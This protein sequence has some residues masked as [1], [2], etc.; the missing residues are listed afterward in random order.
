VEIY[1]ALI[2]SEVLAR[3]CLHRTHLWRFRL[4]LLLLSPLERL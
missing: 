1:W 2:D 3:N 4:T